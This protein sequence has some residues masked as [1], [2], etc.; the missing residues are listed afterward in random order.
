MACKSFA[1]AQLHSMIQFAQE[2]PIVEDSG[3]FK[4]EGSQGFVGSC[5]NKTAIHNV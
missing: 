4:T 3:L 5:K 1:F 2:F